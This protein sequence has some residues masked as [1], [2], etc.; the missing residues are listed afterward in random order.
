LEGYG[1]AARLKR[2]KALRLTAIVNNVAQMP[3]STGFFPT[4]DISV[5]SKKL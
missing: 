1:N 2:K 4:A 5:A 3:S